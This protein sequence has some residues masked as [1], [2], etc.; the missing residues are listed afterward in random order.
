MQ[1]ALPFLLQMEPNRRV[2]SFYVC[3]TESILP[4]IT[5]RI[6]KGSIQQHYCGMD[7]FY[8][9]SGSLQTSTQP[10]APAAASSSCKVNLTA[11][12]PLPAART[13]SHFAALIR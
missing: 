3:N 4:G 9:P 2:N 6:T 12:W 5:L 8:S 7:P 13:F 11:V 1:A 10:S